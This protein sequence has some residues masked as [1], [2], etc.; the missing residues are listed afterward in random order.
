MRT[1]NQ[2]AKPPTLLSLGSGLR[3]KLAGQR[4]SLRIIE[5][6]AAGTAVAAGAF[7]AVLLLAP[8]TTEAET[9]A[10]PAIDPE[11]LTFSAGRSLPSFDDRFQR[12]TGVLDV[13]DGRESRP[14]N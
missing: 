9:V 14:A 10:S 6:S 3:S 4:R 7:W 13:L 12:H 5:V 2:T 11:Q 8:Q 1:L